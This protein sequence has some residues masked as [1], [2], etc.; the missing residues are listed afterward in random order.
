MIGL[1]PLLAKTALSAKANNE[2]KSKIVFTNSCSHWFVQADFDQLDHATAKFKSI[3]NTHKI[4]PSSKLFQLLFNLQF[5]DRMIKRNRLSSLI[6]FINIHPGV[7]D[8]GLYNEAVIKTK[9]K[10]IYYVFSYFMKV[11]LFWFIVW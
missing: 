3:F 8:T 2:P 7:V 1:L 4:Y 10:F 9:L 11:G 5:Y 6:S